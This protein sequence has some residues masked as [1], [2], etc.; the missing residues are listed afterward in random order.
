M[1]SL[2]IFTHFYIGL[3]ILLRMLSVYHL[4]RTSPGTQNPLHLWNWN[5][6]K[7]FPS[8]LTLGSQSWGEAKSKGVHCQ[9]KAGKS[10]CGL[11]QKKRTK[12]SRPEKLEDLKWGK[13]KVGANCY[14]ENMQQVM[15]HCNKAGF[16]DE[17]CDFMHGALS[18]FHT[19]ICHPVGD[20]K[21]AAGYTSV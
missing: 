5:R 2:C 1:A 11:L 10:V 7:S 12:K 21:Q 16:W 13:T 15:F 9:G 17:K 3:A 19:V 8:F 4:F 18:T 14:K 20:A 6:Q